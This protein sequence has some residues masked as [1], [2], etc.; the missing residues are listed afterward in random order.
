M[1]TNRSDSLFDKL[2]AVGS[3]LQE[4][5]KEHTALVLALAV[6]AI[7]A[8]GFE[9]FNLNITI[10]EEMY[11]TYSGPEFGWLIQG[12]WG[13]YLLNRFLF[14]YTVLPFVPLFVA[15]LFHIAAMVLLLEA[16]E[17]KSRLTQVIVGSVGITFPT[18]AYMYTFSTLNFGIGIGLF[19]TALALYLYTRGQGIHKFLAIFPAAFSIAL[20]QGFIPVLI[21]AFLVHLIAEALRTGRI[22]PKSVLSI[23]SIHGLA[24]ILYFAI[25]RLTVILGNVR[26]STYIPGL[27]SVSFLLE[28]FGVVMTRI[29]SL[30]TM[31]YSGDQS[32][33]Y[34]EISTLGVLI[35][36][37]AI[38]MAINLARSRLLPVNKII[39]ASLAFFLFILP[40]MAGFLMYGIMS[41]R[42]LIALPFTFSGLIML[43][44]VDH[45]KLVRFLLL[46]LAGFCVFKFTVST[47]HLFAAS[48][49]AL[50][51]DR[52]TASRLILRIDEAVSESE[53]SD[54]LKYMEVVGYLD[55]PASELVPKAETFGAS[56][57]EIDQGNSMRVVFF[58]QTV[59]LHGLEPLPLERRVQMIEVANAMP[60]WPD[61]DSIMIVGDTVLIKFGPY[62][63][64]QK[65]IICTLQDQL[66]LTV[67][68]F[69]K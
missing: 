39:V 50:Q 31:V 15:L 11:A 56:F 37:A 52:L 20:Y 24:F 65:S 19:C 38:G 7:A 13:M 47:N 21:S 69:C 9:L 49:L 63:D 14:P 28:N 5:I 29:W 54:E 6:V 44:T 25:Q 10:D 64:P 67:Q 53:N 57:F 30:L 42:F 33:Y 22:L 8:Y 27:F 2:E 18:M 43:G 62:S 58:L 34:I 68:G 61:K 48:H 45:P 16:W 4:Y 41:M 23:V 59:G 26:D 36:V 3:Q 32:I 17:V 55:R 46:L 12:R 40:F 35:V 51:E 60:V 66:P 1:R